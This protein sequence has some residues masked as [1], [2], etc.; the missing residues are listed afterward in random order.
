MTDSI[1][2][3]DAYAIGYLSGQSSSAPDPT[4]PKIC[5]SGE[6]RGE[7]RKGFNDGDADRMKGL[8]QAGRAPLKLK[9][10]KGETVPCWGWLKH[11]SDRKKK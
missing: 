5:Q 7:F 9:P 11:P 4:I 10:G 3:K 1:T 8:R 6:L 2:R